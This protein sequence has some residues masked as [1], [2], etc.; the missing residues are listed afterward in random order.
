MRRLERRGLCWSL[1]ALA[2][3]LLPGGCK[4]RGQD[5]TMPDTTASFPSA[6]ARADALLLAATKT[7]LPPPGVVP[8]SLP[9]PASRGAQLVAQY[10]EQCHALPS[11]AMH[12][13]TDWP[14]VVRRM[15]LRMDRLP[16]SLA[17]RTANE[18]DR[19]TVLGY[20]Q[21]NALQVGGPELP[22]G[23][24]REEF[25]EMCSRCHALPD[26]RIHSSGDWP[27]VYLRMERNMERMNVSLPN[28]DQTSR[29]LLYLQGA[30]G[31][32]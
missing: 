15:W 27:A 19:V 18:G 7:A 30:A 21:A 11:P 8:D 2:G 17:V 10:C 23:Q 5:G 4:S 31:A 29:I 14:R 13:A 1:V 16:D 32:R 26:I 28:R 12:S 9:D 6:D 22:A 25:A 24:G 20:L 3:L